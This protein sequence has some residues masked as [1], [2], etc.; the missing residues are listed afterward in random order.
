MF[1]NTLN[2]LYCKYYIFQV[3]VGNNDIA[4]YSAL[5]IIT[6]TL[7]LYILFIFLCANILFDVEFPKISKIAFIT[8]FLLMFLS[9]YF[10]LVYKKRYEKILNNQKIR[11]K[12]NVFAIVFPLL[13][14]ILFNVGW[15]L[16]L[17]QNQG[18][19]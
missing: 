18:R 9:F 10:L 19:I 5:L 16:K 13:G 6:I 14:F 7:N 2:Y 12:S 1:R 11:D 15:I 3:C 4:K 8:I 17:L